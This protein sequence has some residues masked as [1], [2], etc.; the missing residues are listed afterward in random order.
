MIIAPRCHPYRPEMVCRGRFD[1]VLAGRFG[2]DATLGGYV[3][4]DMAVR[5]QTP[6]AR[7]FGEERGLADHTDEPYVLERCCFCSMP[8]PTSPSLSA[9]DATCYDEGEE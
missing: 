7:W 4:L 6:A 5:A 1:A 2:W 8:L 3:S 9:A